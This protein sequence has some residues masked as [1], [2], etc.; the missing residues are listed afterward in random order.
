VAGRAFSG[1]RGNTALQTILYSTVMRR[2]ISLAWLLGVGEEAG[3]R[4]RSSRRATRS[5]PSA[6]ICGAASSPTIAP[7]ARRV[8]YE[9]ATT[10]GESQRIGGPLDAQS[11]R[12]LLALLREGR[13]S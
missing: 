1:V 3:E 2:H 11:A 12:T 6:S 13:P 5:G 9:L 8:R 10:H 4:A 7:S